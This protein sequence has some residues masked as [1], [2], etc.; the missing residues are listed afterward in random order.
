M[1]CNNCQCS[2]RITKNKAPLEF[3]G[4]FLNLIGFKNI[5]NFFIIRKINENYIGN[6]IFNPYSAFIDKYNLENDTNKW[7]FEKCYDH[8]FHLAKKHNLLKDTST[9]LLEISGA[10]GIQGKELKKKHPNINYFTTEFEPSTVE[11]MKKKLNLNCYLFDVNKIKLEQLIP[12]TKFDIIY[13][14][15]SSLF[16]NNLGKL[17][18]FFEK[19]LNDG[20]SVI[21]SI[22][23]NTI[24]THFRN[25]FDEF[26][27]DYQ[28]S[29]NKLIEIFNENNFD[30]KDYYEWGFG[31]KN[32]KTGDLT[33]MFK[34]QN[35]IKGVLIIFYLLINF[36]V[37]L[38]T[39][40]LSKTPV[41]YI[42]KKKIF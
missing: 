22:G 2:T 38:K 15:C 3:L 10:P 5:S 13:I 32:D 20:G 41:T 31:K 4:K 11:L 25:M 14:I 8:L 9:N 28:I 35:I 30:L 6:A 26:T 18:K 16:S 23:K 34:G 24:G 40:N 21:F 12:N 17:I 42:F 19:N 7:S 37:V 29:N 39:L 1:F 27:H 36:K 33:N